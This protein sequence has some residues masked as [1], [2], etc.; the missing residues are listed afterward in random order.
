MDRIQIARQEQ[1]LEYIDA[2]QLWS[3][4]GGNVEYSMDNLTDAITERMSENPLR[5]HTITK[6]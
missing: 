4:F 2:D 1:I 6:K 3:E 5:L